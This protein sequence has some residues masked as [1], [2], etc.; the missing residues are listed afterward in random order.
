VVGGS[1]RRTHED[2]CA[3]IS[4]PC[5]PPCL[6]CLIPSHLRDRGSHPMPSRH[7]DQW[8]SAPS[9][10]SLPTLVTTRRLYPY[11][12]PPAHVK[13]TLPALL[14]SRLQSA[15]RRRLDAWHASQKCSTVPYVW[16]S[17]N[18]CSVRRTNAR[19][20]PNSA[21][22]SSAQNLCCN[23]DSSTRAACKF[24]GLSTEHWQSE[25]HHLQS[26]TA[27]LHPGGA[28]TR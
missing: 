5:S 20:C 26:R 22:I 10:S 14:R 25:E 21:T 28:H 16:G 19:S 8:S 2:A 15:L 1:Y 17:R 3:R 23:A 12:P 4:H 27:V 6:S 18:G 11:F 13:R 24:N 7:S 9:S